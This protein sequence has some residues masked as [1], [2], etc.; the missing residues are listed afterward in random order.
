MS[1]TYPTDPLYF[2]RGSIYR[3][4]SKSA[5]NRLGIS[6]LSGCSDQVAHLASRHGLQTA[7]L[8]PLSDEHWWP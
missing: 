5:V 8:L 6:S 1:E 3:S 2:A 7:C 4:V